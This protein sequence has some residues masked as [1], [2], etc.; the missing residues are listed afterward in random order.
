MGNLEQQPSAWQ[1]P[2]M[3]ATILNPK[4]KLAEHIE[5]VNEYGCQQRGTQEICRGCG[6][7]AVAGVIDKPVC[8]KDNDTIV[9]DD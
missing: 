7:L 9:S 1:S 3:M 8:R 4:Q 2:A 5:F 6:A